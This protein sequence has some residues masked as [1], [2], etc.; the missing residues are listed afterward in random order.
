MIK[1]IFYVFFILPL[2]A[3]AAFEKVEIGAGPVALG[4]ACVAW[5]DNPYAIYYNP[6]NIQYLNDSYFGFSYRNFYAM[7]EISELNILGNFKIFNT[8]VSL[9]I[10]RFGNKIYQEYQFHTAGSFPLADDAAIGFGFQYYYLKIAYYGSITNWGVNLGFQYRVLA[11]F[12]VGAMITNLNQPKI[13]SNNEKLPQ[14]FALGFC[15]MPVKSLSINFELFRDI[16]FGQDYRLGL[17]FDITP[18]IAL[19]A[20]IGD[21]TNSYS[22]GLGTCLN[23]IKF[24]YALVMHEII[25]ISHILTLMVKI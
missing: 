21:K 17:I 19:R 7:N 12:Y 8:P 4:N 15:Y 16:H 1:L 9:G 2:I 11:E 23:F 20:G 14:N 5:K 24:D 13:G 3:R 6:A 22:L 10:N 18:N 25:G